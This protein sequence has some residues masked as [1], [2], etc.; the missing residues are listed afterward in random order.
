MLKKLCYKEHSITMTFF[1]NSGL[2]T[3]S[4]Y[5]HNTLPVNVSL[6]QAA[7]KLVDQKQHTPFELVDP[8]SQ[9]QKLA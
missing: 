6:R 1:L 2:R 7:A 5:I 4:R 9:Q 8:K 3:L